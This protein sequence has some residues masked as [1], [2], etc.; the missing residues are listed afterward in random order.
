MRE[1]GNNFESVCRYLASE[2]PPSAQQPLWIDFCGNV[3]GI[4]THIAETFG[5]HALQATD[6]CSSDS[7]AKWELTENNLFVVASSAVSE[8]TCRKMGMTDCKELTTEVDFVVT[9][10]LLLTFHP[11]PSLGV[12]TI[13]AILRSGDLDISEFTPR[14]I[15]VRT[16]MPLLAPSRASGGGAG[17][18]GSGSRPAS[19]SPSPSPPAPGS[20]NGTLVGGSKPAA[21]GSINASGLTEVP[22]VVGSMSVRPVSPRP[23][24]PSSGMVAGFGMPAVEESWSHDGY[25]SVPDAPAVHSQSVPAFR[26]SLVRER[27]PVVCVAESIA[28]EG[29]GGGSVTHPPQGCAHAQRTA[30][31]RRVGRRG[32]RVTA[33]NGTPVTL[34]AHH[35][36]D[37]LFY[38]ILDAC[39]SSFEK[40]AD[41]AME[42]TDILEELAVP[43]EEHPHI[44]KEQSNFL[45]RVAA[46][47]RFIMSVR[48]RVAPLREVVSSM[49]AHENPFLSNELRRYVRD[50][51]DHIVQLV[52]Q[53]DVARDSLNQSHANGLASISIT[54]DRASNSMNR[55]M[56][57]L[58][59]VSV[60][61][62]PLGVIVGAWGMNVPV[63]QLLGDANQYSFLLVI[64]AMALLST[65]LLIILRRKN[66]L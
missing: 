29:G 62:M 27:E 6:C 46:D 59:A 24:L 32:R 26:D 64:A 61:M 13:Q 47:R 3:D 49:S 35:M 36:T 16:V 23:A 45:Q 5:L 41:Q 28:G 43:G 25:Q 63:P 58:T 14:R 1:F 42:E 9:H 66:F 40:L 22:S 21:T 53:L 50:V 10:D 4:I 17:G 8:D 2:N 38:L 7:P 48:R 30:A 11:L 60:I 51:V 52:D 33:R 54:L 12:E 34:G 56:K 19:P 20:G 44:E 39:V 37:L 31:A 18:S 65:T 55:V 15:A 57:I